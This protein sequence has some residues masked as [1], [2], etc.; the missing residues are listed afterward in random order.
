MQAGVL[1]NRLLLL[2]GGDF[3]ERAWGAKS[4]T[5]FLELFPELVRVDRAVKPPVVEWLD[6]VQD[7]SATSATAQPPREIGGGPAR[8]RIRRDLWL[9]VMDLHAHGQYVWVA[10]EAQ[11]VPSALEDDHDD[12][13]VEELLLPTL[14]PEELGAWRREFAEREARCHA[15]VEGI[16]KRWIDL[17]T[18]T[19]DLPR[20]LRD[21]WFAE[22]KA[23]VRARLEKW[24]AEHSIAAPDDLIEVPSSR[25]R[26]HSRESDAA[27]TLRD[28][29]VRCVETMTLEELERL[30]LPARAVLR[31]RR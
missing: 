18:P 23:R 1:K 24:F 3:D 9:S 31:L 14:S 13:I 11:L 21:A 15:D 17:E 26:E 2:T 30:Q 6:V 28:F 22:L 29:I 19:P 5:R 27:A 4:F 20:Y 25:A 12:E 8:W 7:E 10:G 16:L